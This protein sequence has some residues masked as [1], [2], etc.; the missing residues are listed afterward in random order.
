MARV[1]PTVQSNM[2]AMPNAF[3]ATIPMAAAGGSGQTSNVAPIVPV[4]VPTLEEMKPA[5]GEVSSAF[6]DMSMKHGQIQANLQTLA[7][8]VDAL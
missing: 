7:S 2:F 3:A 8:T 5:F 1:T 4:E 6:Q